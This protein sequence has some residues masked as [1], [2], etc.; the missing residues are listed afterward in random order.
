MTINKKK[1][2]TN[3]YKKCEITIEIFGFIYMT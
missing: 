3:W 2:I 1:K